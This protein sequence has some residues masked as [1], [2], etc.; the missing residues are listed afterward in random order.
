MTVSPSPATHSFRHAVSPQEGSAQSRGGIR[1]LES[2]TLRSFGPNTGDY[3]LSEIRSTE[4][5]Q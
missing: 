2:V 4:S 1:V 5:D 3:G